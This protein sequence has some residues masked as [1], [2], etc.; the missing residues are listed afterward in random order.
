MV[1]DAQELEF[2]SLLHKD[3]VSGQGG[4]GPHGFGGNRVGTYLGSWY[5]YDYA[6]Y[7]TT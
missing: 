4:G 3:T 7:L 5:F 2:L 6:N 1:I